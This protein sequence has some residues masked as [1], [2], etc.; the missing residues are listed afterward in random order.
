V[1][2]EQ[3]ERAAE[4][5]NA[6]ASRTAVVPQQAVK[7]AAAPS[8]LAEFRRRYHRRSWYTPMPM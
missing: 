7:A 3:A 8:A 5:A 6:G 1:N 4:A 2:A